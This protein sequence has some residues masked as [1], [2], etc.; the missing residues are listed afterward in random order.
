MVTIDLSGKVAIVTGGGSGIGRACVLRFAEAG[1][2]VVA[3]D[4]N[5]DKA[6]TVVLEAEK[7]G[8]RSK[9]YNTD[10]TDAQAVFDMVDAVVAEFGKLDIMFNNA[11]CNFISSF[12]DS[13][14]DQL[15]RITEVNLFGVYNGC[16][17]AVKHMLPRKEGII[18]NSS[19]QAGVI[20]AALHTHYT[21]AKFAVR[22]LTQTMALELGASNIRVNA[23][24]PGIIRTPMWEKMLEQMVT[25]TGGGGNTGERRDET[26][27][28][29][30]NERIPMKRPQTEED[31][32][33]ACLFLVSDLARNIT[34]Q[35]LLVNGG[36]KMV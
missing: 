30:V 15:K 8:V 10:V 29:I 33:N 20:G 2:D 3:V 36:Q 19:S 24:C 1:A 11:G 6:K 16:K 17:A 18:L 14:L 21:P 31:I 22:G 4:V 23:I 28:D 27:S 25:D 35:S 32:A 5:L 26:F 12:P 13:T 34:G 7:F 9:A